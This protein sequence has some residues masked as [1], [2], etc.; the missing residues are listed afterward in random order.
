MAGFLAIC[1]PNTQNFPDIN[2]FAKPDIIKNYK[3]AF[4]SELWQVIIPYNGNGD[5]RTMLMDNLD[6]PDAP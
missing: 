1:M 6:C 3:L 4:S 2:I 5:K